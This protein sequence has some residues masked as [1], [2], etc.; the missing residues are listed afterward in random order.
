MIQR[1]CLQ[2]RTQSTAL[3]VDQ[4]SYPNQSRHSNLGVLVAPTRGVAA[5]ITAKLV[6]RVVAGA[7]LRVVAGTVNVDDVAR[8]VTLGGI[9]GGAVVPVE[10]VVIDIAVSVPAENVALHENGPD[11]DL[12]AARDVAP[13]RAIDTAID[14][15]PVLVPALVLLDA[16]HD[17]ELETGDD[18]T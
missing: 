6:A 15:V 5:E 17:L 13:N 18:E 11:D 2:K 4:R 8:T 7:P 3:S 1:Q 12:E 10:A 9:R 14:T 16:D